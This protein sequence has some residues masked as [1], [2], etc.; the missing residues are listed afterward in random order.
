MA[1]KTETE[2]ALRNALPDDDAIKAEYERLLA[3]YKKAPKGKLSLAR[4]LISRAAFLAVTI[5]NLEK[6]IT[7]NGYEEE[8]Q[9]GANQSGMKKSVAA[10]LHVSYTKNLLAMMKQLND[11]FDVQSVPPVRGDAF[12]RF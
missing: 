2:K 3:V 11:M 7:R 5:D 4:K 8:Y 6:E 10:D 1:T 12:E 9:N